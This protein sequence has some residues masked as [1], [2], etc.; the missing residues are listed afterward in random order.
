MKDVDEIREAANAKT[1]AENS[2]STS[3]PSLLSSTLPQFLLLLAR[4]QMI[5]IY[6]RRRQ[7]LSRTLGR[8]SKATRES[9]V[10][11]TNILRRLLLYY[12]HAFTVKQLLVSCVEAL[13]AIEV[14]NQDINLDFAACLSSP[15]SILEAIS[16]SS[17]VLEGTACLTMGSQP[18]NLS[19]SGATSIIIH[20][21]TRNLPIR[22]MQDFCIIL[23]RILKAAILKELEST[24]KTVLSDSSDSA[25]WQVIPTPKAVGKGTPALARKVQKGKSAN[26]E[27][28][29]FISILP[30]VVM[31]PLEPYK[32]EVMLEAKSSSRETD[33]VNRKLFSSSENTKTNLESWLRATVQH[34]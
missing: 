5:Q 8:D 27:I 9:T 29:A 31:S 2:Q 33:L 17:I 24:L 15:E 26:A 1:I 25:E 16:S 18:L 21:P 28:E 12:R 19:F 14:F 23:K 30:N 10:N 3:H 7:R 32:V 11:I 4:L 13:Q 6:K 34:L 22:N 20:L